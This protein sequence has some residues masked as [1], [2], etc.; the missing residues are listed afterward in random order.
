MN[1]Q[2]LHRPLGVPVQGFHG[3][4]GGIRGL[5]RCHLRLDA[6]GDQPRSQRLGKNQHIPG[7]SSSIGPEPVRA[8]KARNAEPVFG[9]LILHRV[10]AGQHRPRFLYLRGASRQ[11]IPQHGGVQAGRKAGNVQ[12]HRRFAS[13]GVHIAEGVG[14]RDLPEGIGIVHHRREKVQGLDHGQIPADP[15]HR[16]VVGSLGSYYQIFVFKFRQLA[17]NLSKGPRTCFGR[18]P[19]SFGKLRQADPSA[20]VYLFSH[21][22]T[23]FPCRKPTL[24]FFAQLPVHCQIHG[25]IAGQPAHK[26]GNRLRQKHSVYP[27]AAHIGKGDGQ[28]NHNHNLAEQ[29]EKHGLPGFPQGGKSRLSRKLEGHHHKSEKVQ[30]QSRHSVLQKHRVRIK[31]MDPEGGENHHAQPDP[32]RIDQGHHGQEA[33]ALPHPDPLSGAVVVSHHRLGGVADALHRQG[34]HGPHGV[35]HRHNTDVEIPSENAQH[36][37][38]GQLYRGVGKVHDKAG[39]AQTADFSRHFGPELYALPGQPQNRFFPSQEPQHPK[40]RYGLGDNGGQGSSLYPH[41][42]TEDHN[43]VQHNVQSR[44]DGDGHH[45]GSSKALGIDKSIHPQAD[46]HKNGARRVNPHIVGSVS[47]GLAAGPEGIEDG[48]LENLQ[49]DRENDGRHHQHKKGGSHDLAGPLIVLSAP[50]NGAQGRAPRAEKIR[51]SGQQGNQGK[52]DS[53]PREGHGGG[54]R[55]SSDIDSVHNIVE[56]IQQL[57]HGHGHCHAHDISGHGALAEIILGRCRLYACFFL[58]PGDL[59][60]SVSP[61]SY[62][63]TCLWIF[64]RRPSWPL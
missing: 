56:H 21:G 37:V 59:S 38:A 48:L 27:Q 36:L 3:G 50:G 8:H 24:L 45:A 26:V 5:L 63:S 53:H 51:K 7:L 61:S 43:G 22:V 60:H 55:Y 20:L 25:D 30:L 39:Q 47:V 64:L 2:I 58:F 18:S 13:H 35:Q 57:G 23:P 54:P 49:D 34:G 40:G 9:L 44:S 28:G 52:A 6:G 46:H 62:R 42:H 41:P 12:R 1:L 29:R 11:N 10:A 4:N 33:D 32:R 17:Q 19:G 16:R 14:R 15:V 31:Q